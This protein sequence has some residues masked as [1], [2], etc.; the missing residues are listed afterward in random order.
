MGGGGRK[1]V[2]GTAKCTSEW[3]W[4]EGVGGTSDVL[5]VS[6]MCCAMLCCSVL[7]C[8]QSMPACEIVNRKVCR[9]LH[10]PVESER[11]AYVICQTT[12]VTI[13]EASFYDHI[14][15][16]ADRMCSRSHSTVNPTSQ[17]C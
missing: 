14:T 16:G 10:P 2:G 6:V 5:Q 8:A 12:G 7:C 9:I 11:R 13:S 4:E 1:G 17:V 3:E 15:T